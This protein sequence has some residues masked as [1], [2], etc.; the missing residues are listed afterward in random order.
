VDRE[1]TLVEV[2]A[3]WHSVGWKV[4]VTEREET[5]AIQ[6]DVLLLSELP[7]EME[8]SGMRV[9]MELSEMQAHMEL[10]VEQVAMPQFSL[11]VVVRV[12]PT[13]VVESAVAESAVVQS[14]VIELML[15]EPPFVLLES[16]LSELVGRLPF[17]SSYSLQ[18]S[19]SVCQPDWT[20]Q[21]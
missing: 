6:W 11:A 20:V 13:A 17:E 16:S 18:L 12:E 9:W 14:A 19:L 10:F 8:L 15:S 7:A 3:R 2:G 5:V 21:R 4:A 1:R